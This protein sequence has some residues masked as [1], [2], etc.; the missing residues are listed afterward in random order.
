MRQQQ[1]LPFFVNHLSTERPADIV[2]LLEAIGDRSGWLEMKVRNGGDPASGPHSRIRVNQ[3]PF[4]TSYP[5]PY[6]LPHTPYT[7]P[8]PSVLSMRSI[9]GSQFREI[10]TS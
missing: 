3:A 10:R 5:S 4:A 6:L 7:L 8:A 2:L 9:Q 1:K